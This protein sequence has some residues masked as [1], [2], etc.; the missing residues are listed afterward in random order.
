ML[1]EK[2]LPKIFFIIGCQRSGTTLMRLV[3]ESHSMISCVDELRSYSILRETE[4]LNKELK[5]NQAK[6]WLGFKTPRITE[7][8]LEPFIADAGADFLGMVN[9]YSNIPMIF[10]VR[11]PLD[12]IASMKKL[13][14][15]SKSWLE[16]WAESTID[17]WRKTIPDFDNIYREE[18]RLL[19]NTKFKAT[20]AGAIYWK[21]KTSSYYNYAN[22]TSQIILVFYE[23]LV[24]KPIPTISTILNFLDVS[25]EDAV[26]KHEKLL[27]P[28][29]DE[30]G[31][32]IGKTDPR[33]P[34][35]TSSLNQYSEYLSKEEISEIIK[36]TGEL[37]IKLGYDVKKYYL[38]NSTEQ[39]EFLSTKVIQ[40][41]Q[42]DSLERLLRLLMYYNKAIA[43]LYLQITSLQSS[44]ENYNKA[45]TDKDLQITS[46]QSSLE[47]YNKAITDKDL[48]I[49]S[50]AILV[51]EL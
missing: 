32:A 21:I 1:I 14:Q 31:L 5:I 19:E 28:E 29:L 38:S 43:D 8:F 47:N 20:V 42:N 16:I 37:M 10:L 13:D 44:L 45:I 50:L 40:F 24:T 2:N 27:H 39:S 36:I 23:N 7:Q 49:T 9:H 3:L 22:K 25:W 12:T 15:G 34:I 11:N 33:L 35:H 17:F 48:Q 41:T 6:K 30:T 4:L 18:I 46:L 26:L 51:R